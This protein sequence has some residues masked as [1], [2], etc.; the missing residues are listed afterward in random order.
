VLGV[1]QSFGSIARMVGPIG[2]GFVFQNVG[3]AYS[4]WLASLLMLGVNL[5]TWRQ[6]GERPKPAPSIVAQA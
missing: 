3:H 2:S 6:R 4:F 1:Q 5:L